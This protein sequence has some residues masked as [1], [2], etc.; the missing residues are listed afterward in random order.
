MAGVAAVLLSLGSA[1]QAIPITGDI[2]FTGEYTQNG[3]THGDLTTATPTEIPLSVT[4][5]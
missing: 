5:G 1:A 3:G 2:G 4:L